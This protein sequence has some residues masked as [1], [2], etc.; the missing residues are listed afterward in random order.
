MSAN[1]ASISRGG[2]FAPCSRIWIPAAQSAS[3]SCP[4][5]LRGAEYSQTCTRQLGSRHCLAADGART[6]RNLGEAVSCATRLRV[7][8]SVTTV[9]LD[10]LQLRVLAAFS[11]CLMAPTDP[12]ADRGSASAINPLSNLDDMTN[13]RRSSS[14]LLPEDLR[15]PLTPPRSHITH[16]AQ[17]GSTPLPDAPQSSHGTACTLDPTGAAS[18]TTS[19]WL[20]EL[21]PSASSGRSRLCV[22]RRVSRGYPA[23]RKAGR[24]QRVKTR[25]CGERMIVERRRPVG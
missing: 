16:V 17:G 15:G 20:G 22:A 9:Q 13:D 10:P 12:T 2:V 24:G 23:W 25:W 5:S 14:Q 18:R 11:S 8:A 19:A 3:D 6:G 7:S 21:S 1:V 4:A